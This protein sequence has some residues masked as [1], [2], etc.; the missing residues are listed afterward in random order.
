MSYLVRRSSPVNDLLDWFEYESSRLSLHGSAHYIHVE[1]FTEDGTYVV[2]AELPGVDPD[3][4]VEISEMGYLVIGGHGAPRGDDRF[5]RAI[6]T[7]YT[8]SY[9]GHFIVK[10]QLGDAP[11]VMPLEALWWVD[12]RTRLRSRAPSRRPGTGRR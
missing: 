2:R 8:V 12:G 1:D 11:R 9:A 3:K 10:S 4:D 5:Q 7:L 6:Q